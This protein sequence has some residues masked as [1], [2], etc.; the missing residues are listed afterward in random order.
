MESCK[1]IQPDCLEPHHVTGLIWSFDTFEL[2]V[3]GTRFENLPLQELRQ[4]FI[5]LNLPFRIRP[6]FLWKRPLEQSQSQSQSQTHH[7][8][9]DNNNNNDKDSKNNMNPKS[10]DLGLSLENLKKQVDFQKEEIITQSKRV[11]RERRESAW[12][13]EE[14][15]P[16]FAY[17]GK[18]MERKDFS[19]VVKNVRDF[20]HEKMGSYYDCCLLNLYPDGDSGMRYHVDPDQG[21]L[22]GYDTAVV[23]VGATRRFAFRTIPSLSQKPM[24]KKSDGSNYSMDGENSLQRHLQQQHLQQQPHNFVVMDGDVTH[25][26]DDCQFRYQHAVKTAETKG[27]EKA[28]RSSLVFKKYLPTK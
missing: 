23:S 10:I 12:Q 16:G 21:T 6:G 8:T 25:M 4:A 7:D 3:D 1:A 28:S 27:E 13:G 20:L 5:R 9:H 2:L 11:V 24:R 17:S 19:P 22:W 15:V 14:S 26:F 18:I